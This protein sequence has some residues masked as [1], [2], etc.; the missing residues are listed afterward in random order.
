MGGVTPL[1]PSKFEYKV[2]EI[3]DTPNENIGK[4]FDEVVKWISNAIGYGGNV[5]I[6]W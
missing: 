4:Y 6:H 5:L 2:L 3:T 1:F